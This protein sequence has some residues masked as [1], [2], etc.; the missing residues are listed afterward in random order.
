MASFRSSK[1][2][3]AAVVCIAI[4][5][6]LLLYGIIVPVLPF[7]LTT[8]VGIP[9]S[10]LQTWNALLLACYT[11][12]LLLVSPLI[13]VYADHT[14]SRRGPLLFGLLALAAST[15]LLCLGTTIALLIV[16]RILQGLSAAVVW[17]V[18]LALLADTFED[19][20]GVAMGYS[21]IAMSLGLLVSPSIGGVV[22][23]RAGYYAVFY[24]AFGCIA[25]DIVLRLLLIENKVN[26]T[27]AAA[28][29]TT[30][31]K[32]FLAKYPKLRLFKS[33]RLLAANWGIIIQAGVMFSW[34]TVLPL[35]V[36][37][38]FHWSSTAAGLIF[39]C[40][41]IPG[42]FLSPS[43]GHLSDRYGARWP[44]L[45]GFLITIPLLVCL[46][47][48]THNTTSQKVL[49]CALL[50]LLGG[51]LTLSNTPLM[52]EITYAIAAEEERCGPGVF[53]TTGVYGLGYG[54]F[55]TSFALGG[56]AGSLLAGYVMASAGWGTL[57]WA[58]AVWMAGGAVVVGLA[59]GGKPVGKESD[60]VD[61]E[62]VLEAPQKVHTRET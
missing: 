17:S 33:R 25:V 40:L 35:Y 56:S 54:L 14:S 49:L 29:A 5:T 50:S 61:L 3:I 26:R 32:G 10:S 31:Q 47:F 22:F 57:M 9:P 43:I 36:K 11:L 18:S 38:T 44:S 39:L 12:A 58:L 8:R 62:E 55:C 19:K 60:Q 16:G 4:F 21:S 23:N 6:D 59:V 46:R 24:V 1:P 20:I 42:C 7:A 15:L 41:Y 30:T 37:S 45:A 13:G 48:V 27:K 51:T 52:A 34:D 53:G 28:A 2:F